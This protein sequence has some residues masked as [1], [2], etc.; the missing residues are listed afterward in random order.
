MIDSPRFHFN[1]TKIGAN[2]AVKG[3]ENFGAGY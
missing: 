2:E 1:L 3:D